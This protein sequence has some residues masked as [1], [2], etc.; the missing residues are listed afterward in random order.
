MATIIGEVNSVPVSA[1]QLTATYFSPNPPSYE[2][3]LLAS[4][5]FGVAANITLATRIFNPFAITISR[6][7]GEVTGQVA[8][9]FFGVAIYTDSTD[10]SGAKLV[11]SGAMLSSANGFIASTITPVLLNPG[12]YLFAWNASN[13]TVTFRVLAAVV[14]TLNL[15]NDGTAQVFTCA[16]NSAGGVCPA[17][18]GALTAANASGLL[19]TKF[20]A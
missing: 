8:A 20:Q 6:I 3:A 18:L 17:T 9:T 16:N 19:L 15:F 7:T 1:A 5:G 11:D 12:M 13:N 14:A 4:G 2:H 10:G